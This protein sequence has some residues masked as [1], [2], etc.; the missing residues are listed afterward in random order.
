MRF[1]DL[2]RLPGLP[3]WLRFFVGP[4]LCALVIVS[5]VIVAFF[6]A[7]GILADW[8]FPSRCPSCQRLSV[9]GRCYF[10]APIGSPERSHWFLPCT[11]CKR[12]FER[13][14]D[15]T[16]AEAAPEEGTSAA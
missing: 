3:W 7:L 12:C 5:G 15:G 8:C 4:A 11:A 16:W 1:Y 6:S 14:D 2:L 10:R 13:Y 9:R